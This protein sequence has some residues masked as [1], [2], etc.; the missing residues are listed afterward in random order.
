M[1]QR[2]NIPSKDNFIYLLYFDVVD[3]EFSQSIKKSI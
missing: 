1:K 3:M 2:G